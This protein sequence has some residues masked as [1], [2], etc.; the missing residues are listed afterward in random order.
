MTLSNLTIDKI[1]C[2]EVWRFF[3]DNKISLTEIVDT[4]C[5]R[6]SESEKQAR[7][8]YLGPLLSNLSQLAEV[9]EGLLQDECQLLQKLLSFTDYRESSVRRGGV[10]GAVRNCVFDTDVHEL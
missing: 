9:R 3:R 10:I 6:K 2:T 1:S 5:Q 4:L 7:L 8:H